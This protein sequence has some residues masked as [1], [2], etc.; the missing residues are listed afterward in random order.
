MN[1]PVSILREEHELL[2]NAIEKARQ[3]QNIQDNDVYH[4]MMHD[5]ILFFRNF[6]E[7]CHFPKEDKILFPRL[8]GRTQKIT[9]GF[10]NDMYNSHEDLE[11]F[12]SEIVDAH[13]LYDY[14]TVRLAMDKY[15]IEL[16]DQLETEER[17]I[18]AIA[19]ALLSNEESQE[20]MTEF[21]RHDARHGVIASIKSSYKKNKVA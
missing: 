2:F 11:Q 16:A 10:V 20:I 6:N 5:I 19:D 17:E 14:R 3:V 4:T 7:L 12:I 9:A 21:V 18:L 8:E 1:N 15:I 13:V